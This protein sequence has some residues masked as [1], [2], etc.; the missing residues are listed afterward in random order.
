MACWKTIWS[1]IEERVT[2]SPSNTLLDYISYLLQRGWVCGGCP[3]R[4]RASVSPTCDVIGAITLRPAPPLTIMKNGVLAKPWEPSGQL[5]HPRVFGFINCKTRHPLPPPPSSCLRAAACVSVAVS[6]IR[7]CRV[8]LPIGKSRPV[9]RGKV[10]RRNH[11]YIYG[12]KSGRVERG[13]RISSLR[14]E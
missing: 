3:H 8:L 14:V 12:N 11:E 4:R 5:S 2:P 1:T 10:S 9:M 6:T 7:G 13:I